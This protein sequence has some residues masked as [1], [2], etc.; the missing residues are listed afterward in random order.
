MTIPIF[1]CPACNAAVEGR[2]DYI[3]RGLKCPACGIGFM[4]VKIEPR[5]AIGQQR[6]PAWLIGLVIA[7]GVLIAL[8]LFFFLWPVAVVIL[9][10]IIA[11]LLWRIARR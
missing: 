5:R 4:P 11:W 8:P 2:A 10:G 1:H 3:A 6:E 7:L 9:L